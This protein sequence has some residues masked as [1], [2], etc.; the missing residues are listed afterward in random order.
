MSINDIQDDIVT[1]FDELDD[2]MDKYEYIINLGKLLEPMD[3]ALKTQ[4][5]TISGCQAKVW[6]YAEVND[7]KMYFHAD[8]DALITKGL[9]M[10][11][12]K[13]MDKQPPATVA[14]TDIYFIDRVGLSSNLSPSRAN[15][16]ASIIKNIKILAR[17]AI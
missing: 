15:G 13:V 1:T 9:I 17:K 6:L 3:P 11:L 12:L 10:L 2:W 4:A 16:L 8:S 5:N 14:E 7:G